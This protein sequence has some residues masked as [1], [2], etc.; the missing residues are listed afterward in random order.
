MKKI[1]ALF[2]ALFVCAAHAQTFTVNTLRVTGNTSM[3]YPP[4][5]TGVCQNILSYGG[6]GDGVTANDSALAAL[7][8]AEP[9]GNKCAY[10]PPG[11]F[12]FAS[13]VSYTMVNSIESVSIV[14]AGS[15]KT[16]LTWASGNGI[17]LNYIG[18]YNSAHVRDLTLTTGSVGGGTA[19]NLNQTA[20]SI[21]NPANT[22]L[23][24][25]I[26]VV[27]R[28][29]D[30]YVVSDYWSTGINVFGVS[31][32]NFLGVVLDGNAAL[33]GNGTGISISGT[34]SLNPVQYNITS[35]VFNWNS[36]ALNYGT[37]TQ[38]ITVAQSNFVG[39]SYGIISQNTVV[40]PDQLTVIGSQ[41]NQTTVNILEN[42]NIPNTMISG[43]QFIVQTGA[44]GISLPQAGIYSIVGNTFV[45][46]GGASNT[47]GIVINGSTASGVVTGN[48]F[49]QLTTAINLQSSS[50]GANI[51]SNAY[52]SNSNNVVNTGT[53]NT[54]GGGSQ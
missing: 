26:G 28:G 47:N 48:T 3:T 7:L 13:P 18:P 53:G 6:A 12:K 19:L 34:S 17:T 41:F 39:G 40:N 38:G 5:I 35:C 43:N 52:T 42:S 44:I 25:V 30:G 46:N 15:D 10:F 22:A 27:V 2:L 37:Y 16:E 31:N 4:V 11:K 9:A 32:I 20:A 8:A 1:I 50:S 49:L 45:K 29:A 51:Q 54:V 21:P 36:V 14:G 24:D 33:G 23:S